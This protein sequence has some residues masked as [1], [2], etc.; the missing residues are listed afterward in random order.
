MRQETYYARPRQ[1]VLVEQD[2]EVL[3]I[4]LR[5]FLFISTSQAPPVALPTSRLVADSSFSRILPFVTVVISP[6]TDKHA[7]FIIKSPSSA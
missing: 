6:S 2:K 7:V 5:T 4:S 1:F 3:G